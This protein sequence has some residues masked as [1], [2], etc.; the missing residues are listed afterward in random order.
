[1]QTQLLTINDEKIFL[2]DTGKGSVTLLFLHGAFI[3]RQ[4]WLAQIDHFASCY[5]VV[6]PDL[7]GHGASSHERA[8]WSIQEYGRDIQELMQALNLRNVVLIGHSFGADVMLETVALDPSRIIGLVDV[9]HFKAVGNPP[10]AELIDQLVAGLRTDFAATAA[11]FARQAL[12]SADT[13]DRLAQRL[14]ADYANMNPA[15]GIAIFKDIPT[16]AAREATL[17]NALTH[18]LYLLHVSYSPTDEPA[19]RQQLGYDYELQLLEGTCH[20]PMVEHAAE[21]NRELARVIEQLAALPRSLHL[22]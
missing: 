21:F 16:Y 12:L 3:H 4:Y 10:P 18:K 22:S 7:A 17:L 11:A 19:L 9:D 13:D 14:F 8:E 5:R 6:A 20:Y 1:M 2:Y 15:V